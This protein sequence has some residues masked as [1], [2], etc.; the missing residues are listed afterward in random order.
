MTSKLNFANGATLIRYNEELSTCEFSNR[1]GTERPERNTMTRL[2][3]GSETARRPNTTTHSQID[4]L[5]CP[6][7]FWCASY[8]NYSEIVTRC[9]TCDNDN[10]EALLISNDESYMFSHDGN[11]GITLEFS[12]NRDIVG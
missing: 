1:Y 4:F 12:K 2:E 7:C 8:F 5:L 9:P 10:V 11:H 6:S 3:H